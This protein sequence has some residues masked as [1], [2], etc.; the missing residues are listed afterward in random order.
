M[1]HHLSRLVRL[2]EATTHSQ[3]SL[4]LA[5]TMLPSHPD[6]TH[7]GDSATWSVPAAITKPTLS[8]GKAIHQEIHLEDNMIIHVTH[9]LNFNFLKKGREGFLV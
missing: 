6:I 4:S 9:I 8:G 1:W 5:F 3:H 2:T 7:N